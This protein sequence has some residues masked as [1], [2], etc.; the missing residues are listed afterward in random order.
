MQFD[1]TQTPV[2]ILGLDDQELAPHV[3]ATPEYSD[4][5]ECVGEAMVLAEGELALL[6]DILSTENRTG[7]RAVGFISANLWDQRSVQNIPVAGYWQS[8]KKVIR[9]GG[10][11]NRCSVQ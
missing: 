1:N 5:L 10:A 6:R 11:S 8:Q 4:P 2:L 3:V 7:G 9:R